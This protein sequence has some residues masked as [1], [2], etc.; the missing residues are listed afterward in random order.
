MT[1]QISQRVLL[2]MHHQGNGP[3]LLGRLFCF[4]GLP[5]LSDR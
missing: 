5:W 3:Y 4:N 1:M 2:S